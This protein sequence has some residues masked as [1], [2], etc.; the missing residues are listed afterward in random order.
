MPIRY[1]PVR[2]GFADIPRSR[3]GEGSL[4]M[5][6]Y[7]TDTV[8]CMS[9]R[10]ARMYRMNALGVDKVEMSLPLRVSWSLLL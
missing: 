8:R 9:S 3:T 7:G 5:K 1:V 2:Q 10:C 6:Q 4:T